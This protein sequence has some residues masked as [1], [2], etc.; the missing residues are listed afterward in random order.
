MQSLVWLNA[1]CGIF[2]FHFS[3]ASRFMTSLQV[4]LGFSSSAIGN[5][6]GIMRIATSFISPAVSSLADTKKVHKLLILTQCIIRLV[7]LMVLWS[8]YR[9]HSL[10]LV[11][12]WI[13]NSLTSILGTGIGPMSDSL[14]LASLEDKSRYGNVRLWGAVTYGVGNLLTGVLIQAYGDFNPMFLACFVTVFGALAVTQLVLPECANARPPTSSISA[15]SIIGILTESISVKMFFVNSILVGAA[16]SLV[17]SLLFVA[18]ERTMK[19]STPI[20]AGASV[21]ISVLFEIPIFRIA[22]SLISKYGTKWMLIVANL[23]WVVRAV[24][25]SIFSSAWI[26]LVL[27][28]FHGVTFGLYY[29]A[30]VHTCV[31]QSPP[32]MESTMQSLLDMTFAGFG[33]ALGTIGGGYLFDI[34]GSSKTFL[35]FSAVLLLS[36]LGVW[37]LLVEELPRAEATP[38]QLLT[39]PDTTHDADGLTSVK[40]ANTYETN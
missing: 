31:K 7:P 11:T 32:G 22:P 14:I 27:E 19:G 26:V 15:A 40:D 35:L 25:Y 24:G 9:S 5:I 6:L 1:F 8:M 34:I 18:M 17:E 33:V 10:S 2:N 21:F 38:V 30:A 16:L 23:A 20:I 4:S 12:F 36:T 37:L 28:L 13:L 3:I 39:Y 29:S